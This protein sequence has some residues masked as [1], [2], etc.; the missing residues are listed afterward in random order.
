V[1]HLSSHSF[2]PE[3]NSKVRHADIGLLYDPARPYEVA[4]CEQWKLAFKTCA[5]ELSIRRNYP[6]QGKGDGLTNWFRQR[7][8][9]DE[10]LGIEL[11][12][13]QKHILK[14]GRHWPALRKLIVKSL[15][16][17]LSNLGQD[18]P[19]RRNHPL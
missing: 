7:L 6:Y 10:Y 8:A 13:N 4:L 18:F 2:T 14:A 5:P 11:E 12:V 1:I 15:L 16:M 17:T 19:R 3:L 9:P